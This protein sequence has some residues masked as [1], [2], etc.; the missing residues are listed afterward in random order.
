MRGEGAAWVSVPLGVPSIATIATGAGGVITPS[1]PVSVLAWSN[2]GAELSRR[3][4][5]VN[6]EGGE[7][8]K[9]IEVIVWG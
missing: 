9:D 4:F 6:G 7:W 8:C 5:S 2:A 3:R 1:T